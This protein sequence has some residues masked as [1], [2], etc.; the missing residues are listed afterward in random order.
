[1][2]SGPQLLT[3]SGGQLGRNFAAQRAPDSLLAN[4]FAA[5]ELSRPGQPM[6][7]GQKQ[8]RRE[9]IALLG[10]AAAAGSAIARNAARQF[11]NGAIDLLVNN[12]GISELS[13]Q[14]MGRSCRYGRVLSCRIKVEE[15]SAP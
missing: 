7:S 10:G 9:F 3:L 6:E 2:G 1:M 4:P 11:G 13:G 8:Q 14:R 5:T 15:E 12:A